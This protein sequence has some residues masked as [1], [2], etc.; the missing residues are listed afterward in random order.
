ML[1]IRWYALAGK[2]G[3]SRAVPSPVIARAAH[4]PR[5]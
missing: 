5:S 2:Y 3:V 1:R 4:R